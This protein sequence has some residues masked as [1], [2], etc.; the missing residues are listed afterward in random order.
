MVVTRRLHRHRL[1][2]TPY[3][4]PQAVVGA[5]GLTLR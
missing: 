3:E 1:Q 5:L 4:S 2:G